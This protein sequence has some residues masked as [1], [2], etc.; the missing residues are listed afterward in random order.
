MLPPPASGQRADEPPLRMVVPVA[1]G[2]TTDVVARLIAESLRGYLARPVIIDSR[3]G[4]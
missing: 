4:A 1:A 2:G 3:P